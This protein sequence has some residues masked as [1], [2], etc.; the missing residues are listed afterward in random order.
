MQKEFNSIRQVNSIM[1]KTITKE[2]YLE[3]RKSES[4]S[5]IR[6]SLGIGPISFDRMLEELGI[7]VTDDK[8]LRINRKVANG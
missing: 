3:R 2:E 7:D 1:K 5:Q 6:L 8:A 4:R